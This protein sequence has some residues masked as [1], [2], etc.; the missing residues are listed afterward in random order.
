[1]LDLDG[2]GRFHGERVYRKDFADAALITGCHNADV[3]DV[4]V[5]IARR[6][7][8]ALN[9]H[10]D[11]VA[12]EVVQSGIGAI[13][14]RRPICTATGRGTGNHPFSRTRNDV[15]VVGGT[16]ILIDRLKNILIGG[17]RVVQPLTRLAVEEVGEPALAR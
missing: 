15:L 8:D 5:G 16:S 10:A 4:A 13:G 12:A 9:V 11:M 14:A 2:P 1:M 3:I 7:L 6:E 17:E